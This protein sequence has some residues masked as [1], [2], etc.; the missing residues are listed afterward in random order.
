MKLSLN[1][2]SESATDHA[3]NYS[4]TDFLITA[5]LSVFRSGPTEV[6]HPGSGRTAT[7]S[8]E[9]AGSGHSAGAAIAGGIVRYAYNN[10]LIGK[11]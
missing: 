2:E 8:T 4:A 1:P 9:V 11:L 3:T 10:S 6:V 5:H 7:G